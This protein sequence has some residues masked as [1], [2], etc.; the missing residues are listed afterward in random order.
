MEFTRAEA[1]DLS[2]LKKLTR[3]LRDRPGLRELRAGK[4]DTADESSRACKKALATSDEAS[5]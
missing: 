5:R 2:V 3:R 4:V 1:G